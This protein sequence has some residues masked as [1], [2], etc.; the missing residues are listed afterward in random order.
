MPPEQ[1]NRVL[2]FAVATLVIGSVHFLG[3]YAS[4]VNA[5]RFRFDPKLVRDRSSDRSGD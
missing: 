4:V 1:R 2:L 3:I 5:M